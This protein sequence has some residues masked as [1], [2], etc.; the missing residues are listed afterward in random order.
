MVGFFEDG[1]T[2]GV[3][4][5]GHSESFRSLGLLIVYDF[6]LSNLSKLLEVLCQV[7]FSNIWWNSSN[8]N[9]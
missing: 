1:F 3:F 9:C 2:D 6:N 4:K 5:F 7:F 8:E